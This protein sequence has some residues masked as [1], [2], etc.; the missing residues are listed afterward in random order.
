MASVEPRTMMRDAKEK[1]IRDLLVRNIVRLGCACAPDLAGQLGEGKT[2]TELVPVLDALVDEGVLRL[3][4][5]PDDPRK[6]S[7]PLQKVYEVSR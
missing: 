2:P 7:D 6:Y 5:D 4:N 3:K 1:E